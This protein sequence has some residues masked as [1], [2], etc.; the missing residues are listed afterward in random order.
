[1]EIFAFPSGWGIVL[2]QVSSVDANLIAGDLVEIRRH[3][4]FDGG[5]A[6]VHDV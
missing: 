5:P 1:M 3:L 4:A 6:R 2:K